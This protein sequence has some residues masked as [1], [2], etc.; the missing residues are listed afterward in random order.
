MELT[1]CTL[2]AKA[3]HFM[4]TDANAA[5]QAFNVANG[6]AFRW[7]DVWSRIAGHFDMPMGDV[8]PM[9]L[10]AFMRDQEDAWQALVQR[11]GLLP[12][13]LA[14]LAAWA[15]GDF[16]FGLD[17]DILSSTVKLHRAGFR[18]T[19]DSPAMLLRQLAQYREARVLP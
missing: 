12:S 1:D 6:D 18:E 7:H 11:H 5:N 16:V 2:H 17:H 3:M 15:Y 8:R 9:R 19:L 14:D 4:A 13:R 10:A